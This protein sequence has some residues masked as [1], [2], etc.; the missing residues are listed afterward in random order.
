M[1]FI[2]VGIDPLDQPGVNSIYK[3]STMEET[4][5]FLNNWI[6]TQFQKLSNKSERIRNNLNSAKEKYI[7][8]LNKHNYIHFH[9]NGFYD[10]NNTLQYDY[11]W[12][13]HI[14]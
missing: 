7:D 4:I 6:Q 14:L 12:S 9:E 5:Q 11:K 13:L 2:L 3:Y 10:Q 1:H 8:H